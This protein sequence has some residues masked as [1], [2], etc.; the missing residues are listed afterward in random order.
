MNSIMIKL[1]CFPLGFV[2]ILAMINFVKTIKGSNQIR[3]DFIKYLENKNDYQ[4][5]I[6]FGFYNVNCFNEKR[7]VPFLDK[8]IMEEYKKN[9][10]ETFLDYYT[11]IK[12]SSKKMFFLFIL[13]F[14]CFCFMVVAMNM[15]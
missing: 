10:D 5:L 15:R 8:I 6:K 11:H 3:N 1:T 2:F 12:K 13:L 7:R 9:K 4:N 14:G